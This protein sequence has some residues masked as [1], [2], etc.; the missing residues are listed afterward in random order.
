MDQKRQIPHLQDLWL[1]EVELTRRDGYDRHGLYLCQYVGDVDLFVDKHRVPHE[2]RDS[3]VN[4]TPIQRGTLQIFEFL[5]IFYDD[6]RYFFITKPNQVMTLGVYYEKTPGETKFNKFDKGLNLIQVKLFQLMENVRLFY[7]GDIGKEIINSSPADVIKKYFG[8]SEFFFNM[9]PNH[10]YFNKRKSLEYAANLGLIPRYTES[11]LTRI[12]LLGTHK[13]IKPTFQKYW[14]AWDEVA[15][16][17]SDSQRQWDAASNGLHRGMSAAFGAL[18][19]VPRV[20]NQKKKT[21]SE[22]NRIQEMEFVPAS[23][24]SKSLT[25]GAL[26]TRLMQRLSHGQSDKIKTFGTL[27]NRV[28]SQSKPSGGSKKHKSRKTLKTRKTLH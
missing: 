28:H 19:L 2:Y 9:F 16:T 11:A 5:N 20:Y 1:N 26:S 24:R 17:D 25:K 21:D 3:N 6:W 18:S 27:H 7:L 13:P 12:P 22:Q 4:V 8:S 23:A 10:D 14:D 15:S